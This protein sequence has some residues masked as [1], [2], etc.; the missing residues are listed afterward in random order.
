MTLLATNYRDDTRRAGTLGF[1]G[2]SRHWPAVDR[3]AQA[4]D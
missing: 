1:H 2:F 4:D 3:H